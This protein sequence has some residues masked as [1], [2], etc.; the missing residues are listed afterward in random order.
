MAPLKFGRSWSFQVASQVTS[1]SSPKTI[2][3]ELARAWKKDSGRILA[4]LIASLRDFDLAEEALQEACTQALGVWT[5]NGIPNNPGAWLLTVARRRAI[6]RIRSN[7]VRKNS[8]A[9]DAI[10]LMAE[11]A[12]HNAE[13]NDDFPDERLRLIFTCCNPAINEPAQVALTLRTLCGLTTK[14]IAKAFLVGEATMAQRIVR[15]KDKIKKAG[16]PFEIPDNRRL[17]D[18]IDVV[19][20]V[21]YLIFNEGYAAS[22][23]DAPL[24]VELCNE[25]IR[26]GRI[27][28]KLSP[29]PEGDGLLALMILHHS[30]QDARM[31]IEDGLATLETQDRKL[32]NQD[33]IAEGRELVLAALSQRRPGPYQIQAAISALHTQATNFA[34]TDWQQI[35]G[36]YRALHNFQPTPVV[37]LNRA[38]ARSHANELEAALIEV[39]ELA[40]DLENYQPFYAARADIYRRLER[41]NDAQ[42]DYSRAIELSTNAL[43]RE[44]LSKRLKSVSS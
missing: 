43:E 38:I 3:Q 31:N 5:K 39:D 33:A 14:E 41:Y 40:D 6:D 32:W 37:A 16:I 11:D 36:L 8:Q 24:R 28:H 10:T 20:T 42:M 12:L 23:G 17:R 29:T 9:I 2:E 4:T 26:L 15:A 25:A 35:A 1:R 19:L 30:R 34:A 22:Q 13:S 7:E 44:F 18:R 21:I 27:V